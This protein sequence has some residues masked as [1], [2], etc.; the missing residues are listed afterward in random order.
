MQS[1]V[2]L[3]YALRVVTTKENTSALPLTD[4]MR[5]LSC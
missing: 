2:Y 5:A 1:T 3:Y 4:A